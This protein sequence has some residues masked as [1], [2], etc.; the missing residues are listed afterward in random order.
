MSKKTLN[1]ANLETLGAKVL[2][3]LLIEV[4]AGSA[5][6]KRR[7]RLELSHNLGGAELVQAIRK[8]LV[9][10]RKSTSFVGWRKR[11]ALIKDL[12]TQVAMIVEK[13]AP[14]DPS[15]A[16]DLLWQFIEIAPSIYERVDDS[17]GDVG[18]VFQS[19]ILHF[20]DI[21]PLAVLSPEA[22][23]ARV[24]TVIQDNG[25]G[26]WDG[27]IGILSDTL[28]ATGLD[29]LR[30]HVEEFA[31]Q[32]N[33]VEAEP[34]DA[35]MFLRELRGSNADYIAERKERFVQSCLQEIA[36][37]A[38]DTQAYV[39]QYTPE[40]LR[41]KDIAAEVALLFLEDGRADDALTLLEGV[42]QDGR[43]F[44]Q[45]AWNHSYLAT[46]EALGRTH[47]AQAH[48]WSC[49]TKTLDRPHLRKYLKGLP[50]FE[51][52]EAED[53]A[54]AY[55]LAYPSFSTALQ[56]FLEWPDLLSAAQLIE[57]RSDEIDGNRYELLTPAAEALR[58]R[59][60][61]AAVLLWRAMIDYALG[62]GRSSRYGHAADHL[63]DCAALD[64]AIESY[65]TFQSHTD[66]FETLHIA[67]DRKTSFWAKLR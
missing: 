51:D 30:Q 49:F 26:E 4:S 42:D 8:R 20:E 50:D 44:G 52:V 16:F 65:G 15:S 40:D 13:I 63:M 56:F 57:S 34:H 12:V 54:R 38:G 32:P 27:I 22:V 17:R 64:E 2:A 62:A 66:Y 10:L 31:A 7:L 25:Y 61:L 1:T 21:G 24:W 37:A 47:D 60:P 59:H 3:E 48:R 55:V 43:D 35:I 46:L 39:A 41:R 9:T 45:D 5:D 33:D 6:I 29:R 23:A 11:K 36:A 28:G 58:A 19:A 67:H 14:K 18:D 53:K